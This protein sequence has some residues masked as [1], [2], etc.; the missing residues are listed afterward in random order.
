MQYDENFRVKKSNIKKNN[1]NARF[2]GKDLTNIVENQVLTKSRSRS[3]IIPKNKEAKSDLDITA[4]TKNGKEN[5]NL[6][7]DLNDIHGVKELMRRELISKKRTK[8]QKQIHNPKNKVAS[9]ER[10]VSPNTSRF[11]VRT[12]ISQGVGQ[13]NPQATRKRRKLDTSEEVKKDNFSCQINQIVKVKNRLR[14]KKQDL[15]HQQQDNEVKQKGYQSVEIC[16]FEY[17]ES[18]ELA[19]HQDEKR[20]TEIKNQHTNSRPSKPNNIHFSSIWKHLINPNVKLRF[21]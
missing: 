21:K 7:I 13:R 14:S 12:P 18:K 17:E 20:K 2:F 6:N 4:K 11:G 10:S 5:M 1:S 3:K 15:K 16:S 9:Q 8:L 19:D